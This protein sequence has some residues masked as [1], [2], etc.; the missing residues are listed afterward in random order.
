MSQHT[1]GPPASFSE[2]GSVDAAVLLAGILEVALEGILVADEQLTIV[3]ASVGA[4]RLF[5]FDHGELTGENINRLI[6]DRFRGAHGGHVEAFKRGRQASLQMDAHR[7]IFALRKDG[8][9]F[10]VEASLSKR[11]SGPRTFFT[12]VLRD[13]AERKASEARLRASEQRLVMAIRTADL[14][15]FEADFERRQLFKSGAEDSFFDRPLTFEDLASDPFQVIHEDD[16]DSARKAWL[17]RSLDGEPFR[18][19]CRMRRDD[20][21]D[22]WAVVTADLLEDDG[23]RPLRLIGAL[24]NVTREVRAR[25]EMKR[26][27]AAAKAA[28]VA[29]TTFL[30]TMSHEIRTPLNGVLGMVQ[31]M[32]R[33]ELSPTQRGRLAIIR[34]SGQALQAIL[35]DVLDLSKIEAGKID[36]EDIEFSFLDLVQGVQATFTPSAN[37]KGL[38]FRTDVDDAAGVYRGDPTRLRQII[39]NL[40]SNAVK[41][42]EAGEVT[43]TA[44]RAKDGLELTVRD[45]GIGMSRAQMSALFQPFSQADAS[46][47]RRFGGT[48]L[49][50][51][52]C[53]E[54]AG[55][56]GGQVRVRSRRRLGSSFTFTAPITYLRPAQ[57]RPAEAPPE[58]EGAA[59]VGELR[60]LAAEDNTTNQLVLRTLMAQFGIEIA[61]AANGRL[62]VEAWAETPV[63]LVLMD[64][65]MPEMDGL[66]ATREIRRL[67]AAAARKRTPIIA[68]TANALSHQ[69]AEYLAAGMDACVTKP[70]DA[71]QL[72]EAMKQLLETPAQDA[73]AA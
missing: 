17:R 43:L 63:D 15:V 13:V 14:H 37:A 62:A 1:S 56:M 26:T 20:A 18:L 2:E 71:V 73:D 55:M 7:E 22:V 4:E 54:L 27:A 24:R 16:R 35:S 21:R 3:A 32:D 34:E 69:I 64:I 25:A 19:E 28:S 45:T 61:I 65:H 46:T 50:L 59:A 31:A 11:T 67:E 66:Q 42:T 51:A 60:I 29:K 72:L 52:I 9:E 6:P 47:T 41:F 44:R 12:V 57:I 48:G 40:V 53:R 8:T 39:Y 36:L 38:S 49:G 70:I 5:G 58:P 68:L 33:D 10:P 23:G 30:A